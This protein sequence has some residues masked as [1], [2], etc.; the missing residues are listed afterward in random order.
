MDL[1]DP[2]AYVKAPPFELWYRMR[3]DAPVQHSTPARLGIEFWSVTGYHEMRSVLN[4][5]ETFGSRY[6]AFLGFAPQARDP[7]WQRML[8]VTDGPRQWV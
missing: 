1:G 5:G 3:A 4:D 8:V 6:G 7:A 2:A